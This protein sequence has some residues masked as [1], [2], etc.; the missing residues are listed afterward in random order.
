MANDFDQASAIQLDRLLDRFRSLGTNCEFG[1]VQRTVGADPIDLLRFGGWELPAE[2]CLSALT[3]ALEKQFEGL[4]EP[5]SVHVALSGGAD[6]RGRR[7]WYVQ[8]SNYHLRYHTDRYDTEVDAEA[9]LRQQLQVLPFL[10]R[11]LIED[12]ICADKVCVWKSNVPRAEAEVRQ[13]LKALQAYGPNCLLWVDRGDAQHPAGSVDDLGGGLFKGYVARF[14]P[15]DQAVYFDLGS[16][17][18]MCLRAH[19][20][21]PALRGSASVVVSRTDYLGSIDGLI[22]D[23]VLGWCWRK[24]DERPVSLELC[25]NGEHVTAFVARDERPDL[26]KA[27]YGNGSNAFHTP[28]ALRG[29]SP[30]AIVTVRVLG[31]AFELPSSGR[32]LGEYRRFG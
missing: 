13:L 25:V 18:S 23:R 2:Q 17:L 22:D 32:R 30:D 5:G 19:D 7:E 27:G 28:V 6:P 10:R 11:K 26:A 16:W 9:A 14:A 8:E 24:G 3:G 4:G 20:T 12:L 29:I 15:L 1:L 31:T 21:I